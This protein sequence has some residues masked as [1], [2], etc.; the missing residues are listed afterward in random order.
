[1]DEPRSYAE[2]MAQAT[3]TLLLRAGVID[4]DAVMS[5]AEEYDRRASWERDPDVKEALAQTAH[6]LRLAP[7]A[8][9]EAPLVDPA[10]EHRAQFEREQMRRRTA[11]LSKGPAND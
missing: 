4:D 1:M 10:S 8:V 11:M 6:G 7:F 5:L 2:G 9:A 3:M